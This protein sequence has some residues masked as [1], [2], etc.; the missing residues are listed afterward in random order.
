MSVDIHGRR[1]ATAL[2]GSA[3]ARPAAERQCS[4]ISAFS[5]TRLRQSRASLAMREQR[6]AEPIPTA[7]SRE[8]TV[9]LHGHL[10]SAALARGAWCGRGGA[11]YLVRTSDAPPIPTTSPPQ[12]SL[13][14]SRSHASRPLPLLHHPRPPSLPLSIPK[15]R[16]PQCP[17]GGAR[18]CNAATLPP[19]APPPLSP[20][21]T[22]LPT[23]VCRTN[24][25]TVV[26]HSTLQST[27]Y[28]LQSTIV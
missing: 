16:A 27:V 28:S 15:P 14:P 25:Y 9:P 24:Y 26:D 2:P 13:L 3:C 10:A 17:E 21:S 4:R 11:A 22:S 7:R 5:A 20:R 19:V 6:G 12:R 8:R 1:H 18:C 23:V